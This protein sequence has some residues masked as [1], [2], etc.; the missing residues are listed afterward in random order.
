MNCSTQP[1]TREYVHKRNLTEE[2]VIARRQSHRTLCLRERIHSVSQ[3]SC[4]ASKVALWSE[5]RPLRTRVKL[6][7]RVTSVFSPSGL[8]TINTPHPAAIC[9]WLLRWI[10]LDT[11]AVSILRKI[12][13]EN[14][15]PY[16]VS[17]SSRLR[18]RLVN[19]FILEICKSPKWLEVFLQ[20]SKSNCRCEEKVCEG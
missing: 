9:G 13:R 19:L 20:Q 6:S 3:L 17:S 4:S 16:W 7:H 18:W 10:F 15:S 8:P 14:L 11:S 1:K 5:I 12:S 2:W